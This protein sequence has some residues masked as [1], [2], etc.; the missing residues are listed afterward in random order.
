MYQRTQP[1]FEDIDLEHPELA[2]QVSF[3]RESKLAAFRRKS[4]QGL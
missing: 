3:S 4:K 1:G 2:H